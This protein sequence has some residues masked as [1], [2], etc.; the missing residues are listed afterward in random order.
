[1]H[2]E[3]NPSRSIDAMRQTLAKLHKRADGYREQEIMR[4][5]DEAVRRVKRISLCSI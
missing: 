5:V 1:M 4:I 2:I 3:R